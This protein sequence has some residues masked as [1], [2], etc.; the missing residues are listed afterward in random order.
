MGGKQGRFTPHPDLPPPGGKGHKSS[1]GLA[2]RYLWV[3]LSPQGEGV[4]AAGKYWLRAVESPCG[5]M[6]ISVAL[7][8][9]VPLL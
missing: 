2:L 8:A 3:K 1:W 9:G 7:T 6:T 4:N 5:V